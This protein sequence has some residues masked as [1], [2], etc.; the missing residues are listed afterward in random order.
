MTFQLQEQ[1]ND[2]THQ[3]NNNHIMKNILFYFVMALFISS[4]GNGDQNTDSIIASGDLEKIRSQKT[5]ISN[6]KKA[7][8]DDIALL[9]S[10]IAKT[11]PF[12]KT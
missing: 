6:Q 5:E 12:W 11:V 4:C 8:E 9:D 7:L 10:V 1:N 3:R 2:Y